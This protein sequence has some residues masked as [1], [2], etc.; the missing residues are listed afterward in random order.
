MSEREERYQKAVKA[1]RSTGG[2]VQVIK[3]GYPPSTPSSSSCFFLSNRTFLKTQPGMHRRRC[4]RPS[5]FIVAFIGCTDV[6]HFGWPS[7]VQREIAGGG[8]GGGGVE[9]NTCKL[10]QT[11]S[12][13][14][15]PSMCTDS[16]RVMSG[17]L[18]LGT[19]IS[20]VGMVLH[21]H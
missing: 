2:A 4:A 7:A 17:A 18:R 15:N 20:H 1:I 8:G 19:A 10:D 5:W 14:S 13:N 3:D 6:M 21:E 9:V 16:H 12:S 11:T